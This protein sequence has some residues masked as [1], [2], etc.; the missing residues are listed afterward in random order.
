MNKISKASLTKI[1]YLDRIP[2]LR[3]LRSSPIPWMVS[4]LLPDKS[5]VLFSGTY[6]QYKSWIA[7]DI[8]YSVASGTQ[9]ASMD[10]EAPRPVLYFDRENGREQIARRLNRMGLI[11]AAGLDDIRYW[12]LWVPIPMPQTLDD[13]MMLDWCKEERGLMVFDSMTRFHRGNENSSQDMAVVME[14]FIRLR[15]EG[16]TIMLLHHASKDEKN[17]FRGSEEIAAACDICYHVAKDQN[18]KGVVVLNQFKNRIA[19]ERKFI[20]KLE[21]NGRFSWENNHINASSSDESEDD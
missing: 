16:A 7:L 5:L 1:P 4:G 3:T 17:K 18:S 9:F 6:G 21:Q 2:G 13:Q 14:R 15:D 8:A 11:G 10:I 20:L 19:E 12:G